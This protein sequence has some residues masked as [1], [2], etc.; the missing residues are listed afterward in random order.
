[1]IEYRRSELWDT[2]FPLRAPRAG[3]EIGRSRLDEDGPAIPPGAILPPGP[4]AAGC[5]E[6]YTSYFFKKRFCR[7]ASQCQRLAI[8]VD[9]QLC[10]GLGGLARKSRNPLSARSSQRAGTAESRVS[11]AQGSPRSISELNNMPASFFEKLGHERLP[12]VPVRWR[13]MGR[14]CLTLGHDPVKRLAPGPSEHGCDFGA[15]ALIRV[16]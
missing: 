13:Q 12:V 11:A 7:D 2:V 10:E 5:Q 15:T 16:W 3:H 8:F 6:R 1:M 14:D 9:Q 4:E